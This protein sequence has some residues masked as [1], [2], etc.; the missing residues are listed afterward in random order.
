MYNFVRKLVLLLTLSLL[1]L[2]P[3]ALMAQDGGRVL[4]ES[5]EAIAAALADCPADQPLTVMV[6]TPGFSFPFFVHM[7]DQLHEEADSI[8]NITII[9]ADAQDDSVKQSSDVDTA[10]MQGVDAIIISPK[11]VTALA[12]AIQ[13]AVD[14]GIP[15]VTIDRY[16]EGVDGILAHV[17]AENVLG[18]EAQGQWIVE[19]YP[20]GATVINLQGTPGAGPAIARN[21]GLHNVL[22]A[23]SEQYPIVAEQTANFRR[24]EGLSVTSSLL[25]SLPEAPDVIVAAN[26]DM[27]LG[28]IQAVAEA[29]L[30]GQVAVLGF[31]ALPEAL[32]AVNDGTLAGTV[33]QFPGGQSRTAM[34]VAAL[35][36]RGCAEPPEQIIFL[37]PVLITQENFPLAERL[38]EVEG[39]APM[40]TEEPAGRV[41]S[42]SE[43]AIAA[44]LA[45]CPADQ[46]LTVMVSTPGFS[47]P[48]FVHMVDQLHEEADS[49]GNITIIDADAQDDSVKQSSDVDTAIMQGV[50]AIIIS[51]K[52]V[53]ALAPAIQEAVDA[54]IPVVTIDRYVEGVD[55]ILAHVGAENVLGGEAQGQWIVENYPD[56]ATVINLQGTPGAGPAIAR[57]EG[58]HNVLDAVSEQYPIVAEQTANFRRDE[59]LSVTSSLLAS[60]P[61][62]PDVIV[63][64][65]DD[66]ALGAIQAVAEA[67]L[68]GQVAVLGFD[69][70]P[71]ALAAVNDGTLAGTVEQFPG[72]QSRTAMRVA[73]LFGRG[74]AEPPEQII[75]LTPV[76]I[77]QENFPLAERLG[78]VEG[79]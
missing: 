58:L 71:E 19:N 78:E 56:G 5:E 39:L 53:T 24:D 14:A 62:A 66:M 77:T 35:F 15:V 10:I 33:E 27:A 79:L 74:C 28:A 60:L 21:E 63:A 11:D 31:D 6:S 59:G 54:G 51:P 43:E 44:A 46:P 23:V 61:E 34:R 30:T 7:V 22:D 17:G 57:N 16:V 26:D 29:G 40:A 76:L 48:F 13:E 9:D 36:G 41:L 1:V 69:A 20:D 25:A 70:L 38:G 67:G 55:G 32:A 47:F 45:D 42:E 18:G 64:A 73:A 49:I 52:D 3:T 37:T 65:N 75:F 50:D 2:G 4:S 12:P 8:G 68:T 72:G